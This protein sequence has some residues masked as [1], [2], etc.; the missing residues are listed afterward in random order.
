MRALEALSL[1]PQVPTELARTIQTMDSPAQ[2]AD[3]IASFMDVK[4]AE[5][6]ELLET[7]DLKER[8]DKVAKLL[9]HRVEVL[10]ITRDI[11]EQTQAA[12]GE[13]QREAV[14][15]EQMRQLQ[16]ELG[17]S[18]GSDSDIAELEKAIAASGMPGEVEEHEIT[19]V[20]RNELRRLG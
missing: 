11:T 19:V 14:L 18:E 17:E 16:K 13:R 20:P 9:A 12:L 5:K 1:L 6:Q 3:L 4:P 8:L 10:K 7:L 15:R 2:L